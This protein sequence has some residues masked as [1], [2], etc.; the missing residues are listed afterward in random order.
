M[1][2]LVQTHPEVT[3]RLEN[4]V[5]NISFEEYGYYQKCCNLATTELEKMLVCYLLWLHVRFVFSDK[6]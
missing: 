3:E 1:L 4:N 5:C 2:Q 6:V